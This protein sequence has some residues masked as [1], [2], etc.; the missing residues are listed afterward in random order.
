MNVDSYGCPHLSWSDDFID[1]Q[2][3]DQEARSEAVGVATAVVVVIPIRIYQMSELRFEASLGRCDCFQK[4]FDWLTFGQRHAV[5]PRL[6]FADWEEP[7]ERVVEME[8][9]AAELYQ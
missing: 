5:A 4:H 6:L 9:Y 8:P 2:S 7:I 1:L 3:E